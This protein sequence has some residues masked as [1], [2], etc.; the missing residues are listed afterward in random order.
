MMHAMSKARIA[1]GRRVEIEV[2]TFRWGGA[3]LDAA[4]QYLFGKGAKGHTAVVAGGI[5]YSF[6]ARGWVGAGTK[7]E[8]L[9]QNTVRD[10]SGQGIDIPEGDAEKVQSALA[11]AVGAKIHLFKQG[12][13]ACT[14]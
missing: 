13:H 12:I 4:G 1:S 8:D 5:A 2:L 6:D 9:A 7:E 10:A 11:D 14:H 3:V